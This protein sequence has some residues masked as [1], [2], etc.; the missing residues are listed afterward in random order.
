[1]FET[2]AYASN[3]ATGGGNPLGGLIPL[4]LIFGVFYFLLIRPQQ[5]RQKEHLKM[6]DSLVAGDEIVTQGG[7]YGKITRVLD[8]AT[9]EVEIA[10]GVVVKVTKT[11]IAGKATNTANKEEK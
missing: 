3:G 1:M 11:A 7:I 8:P 6:L 5:K 9:Y 4:I 10:K 2:L